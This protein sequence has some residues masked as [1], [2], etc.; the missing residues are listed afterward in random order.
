VRLQVVQPPSQVQQA[1]DDVIA[2]RQDEERA[3]SKA[4]GDSRVVLQAAEAEAIELEQ[5]SLSYKEALILEA[6]G[7]GKRFEALLAEYQA[8][9]EVTRRRLYLE[10]M[11]AVLPGIEKMI[12]EPGAATF[13]PLF[14][15]AA[16][17]ARPRP[18]PPPPAA[19]SAPP[20]PTSA[21]R[22][23]NVE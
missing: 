20:P 5:E 18:A 6:G 14:A 15:P 10:T 1:F 16:A 7:R 23:E 2:A 22:S 8:A 4:E 17:G 19:V 12:V 3:V 11:E 9:P 21:E 13:I